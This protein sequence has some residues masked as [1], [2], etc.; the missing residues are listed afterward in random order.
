MPD[1][2]SMYVPFFLRAG[3]FL[4]RK[5]RR[6]SVGCFW[7][8]REEVKSVELVRDGQRRKDIFAL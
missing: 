7:L 1:L 5:R 3:R 8:G 6:E 2:A 4:L